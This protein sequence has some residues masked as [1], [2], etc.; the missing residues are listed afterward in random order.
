MNRTKL[1]ADPR[2]DYIERL[3][4]ANNEWLGPEGVAWLRKQAQA[5]KNVKDMGT[6]QRELDGVLET[7]RQEKQR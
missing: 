7:Y 5:R 2:A 1:K 4:A 6:Y 3:A